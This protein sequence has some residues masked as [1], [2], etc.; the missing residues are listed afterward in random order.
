MAQLA[1]Y[2]LH[3]DISH[4]GSLYSCIPITV[5]APLLYYDCVT[6]ERVMVTSDVER[7]TRQEPPT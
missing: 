1:L 5:S 2:F 4:E 6:R 7:G 3:L